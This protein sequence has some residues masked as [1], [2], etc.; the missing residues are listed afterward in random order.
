MEIH[1]LIETG[2]RLEMQKIRH[3]EGSEEPLY[4]S[5]FLYKKNDR[6]AVIEMPVSQG[7][8]VPLKIGEHYIVTFFTGKGLYRCQ[9]EVV[10][11]FHEDSL[12]VAVV[13]FRSAFEKLQRRQYYR[14]ECLLPLY[15]RV[16]TKEETLQILRDKQEGTLMD[17]T[18]EDDTIGTRNYDGMALDI[19][20]GGVRFNSTFLAGAG[21][22]ILLQIPFDS[23]DAKE[24]QNLFA[25]VLT[26]T[27]VPNRSGLYEHRVE[28]VLI[29][30]EERERIIR[31]IFLEERRRRKKNS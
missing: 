6:E 26:A 1:H 19:S 4:V 18:E 22:V 31:Y 25:K 29:S 28:F 7:I 16:V 9:A 8:L 21:K 10:D 14:M 11:R 23:P 20:G 2:N 24:L 5:K 12:P 27:P 30:N 13:K 3:V 17:R 15:F